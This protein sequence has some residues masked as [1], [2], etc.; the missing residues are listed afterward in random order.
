MESHASDGVTLS[1]PRLANYQPFYLS[2]YSIEHSRL[3]T[4]SCKMATAT[5][6]ATDLRAELKEW[7]RAFAA[8]NGGRKAERQDIKSNPDIG[9]LSLNMIMWIGSC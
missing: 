7:E 1:S 4:L 5:V 6:T 9:M 3:Y 8:A 2:L